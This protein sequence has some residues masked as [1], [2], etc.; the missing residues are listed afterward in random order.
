M[1]LHTIGHKTVA[2]HIGVYDTWN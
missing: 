1:H 2:E